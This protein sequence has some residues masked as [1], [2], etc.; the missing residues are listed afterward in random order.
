VVNLGDVVGYGASPN[1]VI[2]HS[3][4]LRKIVVRGNH[5]KACA[6]ISN[7]EDF[8]PIAGLAA[9][10]TRTMLNKEN[11]EWLRALPQGPEHIDGVEGVQLVH[12]SPHD[13]DEYLLLLPEALRSLD[14]TEPRITF[15]GHTHIQGG[16]FAGT[17][18]AAAI[19][20]VY[21]S[22]GTAEK[23][24]FKLRKNVRYLINPGSV[25]QPRDGDW[26]AAFALFDT[27]AFAVTYHRVNYNLEQ[28]QHRILEADLPERLATRLAQ[29]R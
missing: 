19:R 21:N 7:M 29:G 2:E 14:E 9:L 4:R 26:R 1:E 25:G 24:V 3:R 15:F 17:D 23:Y 8:N 20:P 16:F 10:W 5:D 6:G 27:E 22:H 28:A 11:L 13:E 18:E 12:G